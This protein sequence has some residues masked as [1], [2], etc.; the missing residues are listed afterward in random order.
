MHWKAIEYA[1]R[2]HGRIETLRRLQGYLAGFRGQIEKL[3]LVYPVSGFAGDSRLYLI[4]RGVLAA[5]LPAPRSASARDRARKAV[6][7]IF[8]PV[9]AD[10]DGT[11]D[12]DAA[13]EALLTVA[14]FNR[15]PQNGSG[16]RRR[17]SGWREGRQ[18]RPAHLPR[19]GRSAYSL[20]TL[21]LSC[22]YLPKSLRRLK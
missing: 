15:H 19:S 6:R 12:G 5:E 11:L 2:L 8:Q 13:A 16:R 22:L 7:E 10:R 21:P 3:N 14:W 9:A 4:R 20:C 18:G 17:G 1:A